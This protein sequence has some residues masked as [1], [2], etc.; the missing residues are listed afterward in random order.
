MPDY[1]TCAQAIHGPVAFRSADGQTLYRVTNY[2]RS[3]RKCDGVFTLRDTSL[4]L[5]CPQYAN[6]SKVIHIRNGSFTAT[7][8]FD[9]LVDLPV[10][11][12][13]KLFNLMLSAEW[14]NVPDIAKTSAYL[15]A[16]V[17]ES[18]QA[19]DDASVRFQREW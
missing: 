18:K 12:I 2:C 1:D 6:R 9:R 11:N 8:L 5:T 16:A 17:P 14:E 15:D 3:A 13:R 19:W 4:C 7:V 10:Q